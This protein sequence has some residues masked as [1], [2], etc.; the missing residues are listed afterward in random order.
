MAGHPRKVVI[1]GAAGRDFHNFNCLYRDNEG[2]DVVAFTAAQIPDIA[3]RKY[4]AVLAGKLYP[5]G[6][7]IF[8]ES[9]LET[10]IRE[11][12]VDD[13]V[14]SY[15]DVS[16]QTVMEIGE[17]AIAAG[18]NYVLAG[19]R[20]TAL[21]SKKPVICVCAIRTGCGKSQTSRYVVDILHEMGL[22]VAVIRHPMPYGDLAVQA[23]QRFASYEDL[24]KHKCT[25][26][27]REEYEPHM[28]AGSVLF[29]GVDYHA[30]LKAAEAEADVILWDGGNNDMPF[31]K[32]N[33]FITVLDPLRPGHEIGYYP[34]MAN[35]LMAD[36][37]V[38]NKIDSAT[39]A[40]MEIV[41][42]SITKW[43]PKAPVIEAESVVSLDEDVPLKGVKVLVVED[44]PTL[45]HGG[46]KIGAGWVVAKRG[47]AEI[48]EPLQYAVG[49]IKAT[50]EKYPHCSAILPA[51]G[52]SPQQLADLNETVK[53]TPADLII[54]G[55]PI[56]LRKLLNDPRKMVRVRYDLKPVRGPKLADL[57]KKILA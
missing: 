10:L 17:R 51:M 32:P 39:P 28:E 47:G 5:N 44:G 37:L 53:R 19:S 38:I 8:E 1:V 29:A 35:L 48:V 52:Y 16:H 50:Y 55:T 7:P 14:F 36:V 2:F 31:Y 3:G 27:E 49:S 6:I 13:V 54:V 42:N 30:I 21:V 15:S 41:K 34:G 56:D 22:K 57:I 11:H 26:E 4:P 33:L 40:D 9:E 24:A 46:M 45:T 12:N 23:V 43:N 20:D 25:I 18:A